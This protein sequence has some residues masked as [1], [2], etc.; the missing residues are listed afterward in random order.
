[1]VDLLITGGR[2]L[3]GTGAPWYWADVAVES[4]RIAGVGRLG[5]ERARKVVR[6]D[7]RMVC[8]GFIDIH[9]HSDLQPLAYPLHECKMRQGVTTDVIGHDG[10]GLAPVTPQ[11]AAMLRRQLAGWNGDPDLVWDWGTITTYLDR[12][13]GRTAVNVAMMV[14]HGTVRMAVMGTDQ[15]KPSPDE[16]SRM[17]RLVDQGMR[18]GAVGLSTGLTYAPAMFS[19]DDEL[20]EL[21]KALRPYNGFYAP[22][23]RNYGMRALQAYA[24]SLEIGRRAG[25]PVHLT[26]C[27]MAFPVNKGRAAELLALIDRA[28]A[29]GI[30]VTLDNYPYLVGATYMHANLPSWM[31]EGGT[32]ALLQRLTSPEILARLQ[33]EMEVTGSDG[34]HG[35]PLGWE[36]LQ[37]GSILGGYDP[38]FQGMLLPEAA[39]RAGQTPF[40]FFVDLLIR[41]R[42][43]VSCLVHMGYEENIQ[44]ILQHPTH[45]VCSDGILI[46]DRPH[47]RG[48]GSHVRFL[49]RY[50]R[51]LGLLTWEEGVRHMTSAP[52]RRI[53]A[54]DR[55]L[56]RPGMMADLVVFDPD[57]LRDTATYENPKQYAEGVDFVA[58]NGEPVVEDGLPT[59]ATPGRSLR[60]PYGRKPER[61]L[62]MEA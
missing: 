33:T 20:V 38:S 61:V 28:R 45:M 7:G 18:E 32:E 22:H 30:E 17:R 5:G 50:V 29:D 2:L 44:A 41:T 3:D 54:M 6:A 48:W 57:R 15:R 8:P 35:V 26:H 25:V 39:A 46:G 34:I 21:C 51:E 19:D 56:V 24:D 62:V 59:G 42:L 31:H 60:E 40:Q 36:M 49:A 10:L 4:G 11:T 43:G 52:A 16:M 47:P 23:H 58:V 37:I 1:M 9:S 13:D 27:H 53:G 14:P 55:G 12:F